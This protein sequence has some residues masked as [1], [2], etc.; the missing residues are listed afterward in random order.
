MKKNLY[1]N[2]IR[3]TMINND[4]DPSGM[5]DDAI[6]YY[7]ENSLWGAY[8]NFALA[9]TVMAYSIIKSARI[10]WEKIKGKKG[11][12]CDDSERIDK[13]GATKAIAGCD[14]DA[15]GSGIYTN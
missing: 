11:E 7:Y 1:A 15:T 2:L 12:E 13:D 9:S 4:N 14:N 8:N 3:Y 10:A 5:D 6:I